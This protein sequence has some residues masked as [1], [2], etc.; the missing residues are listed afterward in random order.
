MI[1]ATRF[2]TNM[3]IP[4]LRF[5]GLKL[6]YKLCN[7]EEDE[8]NENDSNDAENGDSKNGES[9][10]DELPKFNCE[11]WNKEVKNEKILKINRKL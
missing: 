8:N 2:T 1:L 7:H 6:L 11:E 9:E 3:Y 10:E 4:L 5:K